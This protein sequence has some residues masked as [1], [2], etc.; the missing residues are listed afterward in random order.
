MAEENQIDIEH[1]SI[2]ELAN[3]SQHVNSGNF[4]ATQKQKVEALVWKKI[5][6]VANRA[7]KLDPQNKDELKA[8]QSLL[9]N[10]PLAYRMETG[11]LLP[12]V[13]SAETRLYN[14][15]NGIDDRTAAEKAKDNI[16]QFGSDVHKAYSDFYDKVDDKVNSW[17]NT[18]GEKIESFEK[19]IKNAPKKLKHNAKLGWRFMRIAANRQKNNTKNWMKNKHQSYSAWYDRMDDKLNAWVDKAGQKIEAFERGLANAP[20]KLQHNAK[21]GWRFMR[22]AANRQKNNTK[23][24][25]KNKH[26]SY[27]AWYDRMDDKLNAWVDK[28]GQKIEAFERGLANAPK[29]LKHNAKLG[30]RF[31]RIAANRQKNNAKNWIK[32]K[33]QSY[34]AWHDRIDDKLNAWVDKA[35]QKIEAFERGL[36]NAPKNIAKFGKNSW[37]ALQRGWQR[38]KSIINGIKLPQVKGKAGEKSTVLDLANGDLS[39]LKP[40]Q[41]KNVYNELKQYRNRPRGDK[42]GDAYYKISGYSTEILNEIKAKGANSITDENAEKVAAWLEVNKN[43]QEEVNKNRAYENEARN[44][45]IEGFLNSRQGKTQEKETQGRETE[46]KI[47]DKEEQNKDNQEKTE[48]KQEEKNKEQNEQKQTMG[49]AAEYEDYAKSIGKEVNDSFIKDCQE[50]KY[51]NDFDKFITEQREKYGPKSQNT[52]VNKEATSEHQSQAAE[53]KAKDMYEGLNLTDSQR[54]IID[55]EFN[56]LKDI[57]NNPDKWNL[58][59]DRNKE[60]ALGAYK[61]SLKMQGFSDF[62]ISDILSRQKESVKDDTKYQDMFKSNIAKRNQ[63]RESVGIKDIEE[64]TGVDKLADKAQLIQQKRGIGPQEQPHKKDDGKTKIYELNPNQQQKDSPNLYTT[65]GSERA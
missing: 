64:N 20:K 53:N 42:F 56:Q 9:D 58:S 19:S 37:N 36:A 32:N 25:M 15:Q 63:A 34:S 33:H 40:E 26:Q 1:L 57:Y 8:F 31:M 38:A 4:S 61:E 43:I 22:I 41:I 44:K 11:G 54:K 17:V 27:S 65:Y 55:S 39:K 51:K 46:V 45:E 16:N 48:Q 28:A 49:F 10:L 30:W 23:N 13:K 2:V 50:G 5:K 60:A 6:D 47:Q 52:E 35:G 7:S 59:D 12:T 3:L 21:L 29:K 62:Q 14:A 24:W 18:A